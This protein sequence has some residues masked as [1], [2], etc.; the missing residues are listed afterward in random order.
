MKVGG[1]QYKSALIAAINAKKYCVV[2]YGFSKA[3]K[4]NSVWFCGAI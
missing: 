4:S 1:Y 2:C 3:M